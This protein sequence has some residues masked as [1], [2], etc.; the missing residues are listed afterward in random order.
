MAMGG[1]IT[2][3]T[4]AR[5]GR[6][7]YQ[8]PVKPLG[9][10]CGHEGFGE[11][12]LEAEQGVRQHLGG[13][14]GACDG[15]PEYHGQHSYH[16]GIACKPAGENLIQLTV[17]LIVAVFVELDRITHIFSADATRAATMRSFRISV[18]MPYLADAPWPVTG[19]GLSQALPV[20]PHSDIPL[21]LS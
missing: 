17:P 8:Q 5:T 11:L 13:V 6:L 15:E 4:Q 10:A 7:Q 14:I 1:S 16:D 21:I 18:V 20:Y 19:Q 2:E 9:G 12:I 3:T